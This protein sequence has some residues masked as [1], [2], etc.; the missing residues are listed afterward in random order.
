MIVVDV[1]TG[2]LDE[3]ENPLLS[4]GAVDFETK[5]E[6]YVEMKPREGSKC[7]KEA[8]EINGIEPYSKKWKD[9]G[10]TKWAME[11]FQAWIWG[12]DLPLTGHN[13]SFDLKFLNYNFSFHNIEQRIPYRTVDL[14][15]IAHFKLIQ[16]RGIPDRKLSSDTIYELLG[17]EPEPR[18]HNA[19]N[20]AKWEAEAFRRL[21]GNKIHLCL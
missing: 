19:L 15:S 2:G 17:M 9:N 13:P 5:E 8:L 20:G 12:R 18:P 1:E 6:F 7:T 16:E 11:G 3:K 14:H 4:I 21:F 10:T